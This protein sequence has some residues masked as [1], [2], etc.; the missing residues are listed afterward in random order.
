[1]AGANLYYKLSS[2]ASSDS[3][4]TKLYVAYYDADDCSTS[5]Y[6]GE[7]QFTI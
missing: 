4:L 2:T 3:A 6:V 7:D 5:A 1:V